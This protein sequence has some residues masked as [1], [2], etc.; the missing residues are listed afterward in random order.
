MRGERFKRDLKD[1]FFTQRVGCMQNELP[2]DVV[3]AGTVTTFKR[4]L[5]RTIA[6]KQP[7]LCAGSIRLLHLPISVP[8]L[9]I[10]TSYWRH[11]HNCPS[12]PNIT[13]SILKI[14][15]REIFDSRG[16]PTIEVDLYT[17]K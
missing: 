2:E 4:L 10:P 14:H 17:G 13:M 8:S 1:N 6:L 3:D 5:D 11:W 9:T 7:F 15:A 16:N 12:C